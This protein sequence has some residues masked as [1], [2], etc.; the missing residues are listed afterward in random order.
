MLAPPEVLVV[1]LAELLLGGLD[2][3]TVG[4][5]WA[6]FALPLVVLAMLDEPD[7]EELARPTPR[8]A[9]ETAEDF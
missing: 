6:L 7:A 4:P 1:L 2:I 9:E 8:V 3:V 5:P